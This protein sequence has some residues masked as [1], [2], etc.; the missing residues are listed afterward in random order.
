M[1]VREQGN[2]LHLLSCVSPEW[3]QAGKAIRVR[4]APTTFGQLN[5]ELVTSEGETVL[6]LDN[7]F[8]DNPEELIVH[9]PWFLNIA[10]AVSD[11]EKI[12]PRN[13]AFYLSP[14]TRELKLQW[15]RL[16]KTPQLSYSRVVDDY[17]VEYKRRYEEF[18]RTGVE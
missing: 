8:A 2:D 17:K 13:G 16:P 12:A 15:T 14:Q 1:L 9:I 18:L 6:R 5:L 4:R 3:I 11:G 7:H 10:E